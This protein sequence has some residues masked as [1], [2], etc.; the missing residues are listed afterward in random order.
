MSIKRTGPK[1]RDEDLTCEC[2]HTYHN[3]TRIWNPKTRLTSFSHVGS[4][5]LCECAAYTFS[6]K[7]A[8]QKGKP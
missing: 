8:K 4:C 7:L 2:G 5:T 1:Q 6:Q 3:H